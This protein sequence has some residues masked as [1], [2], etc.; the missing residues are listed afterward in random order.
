M[1]LWTE[2]VNRLRYLGRRG[3][4][5]RELDVEIRFHIE[6]RVAELVESGMTEAEAI[7]KARREFGSGAISQEDSRSAWQFGWLE[8][9]LAD[10]RYAAR[11]FLHSPTFAAAAI[12][13]LALGIG[14]NTL[15]F[16]LVDSVLLRKLPYS[17]PDRLVAV[18][19]T[20]PNQPDQKMGTNSGAYF[21][22][23]ENNT[24]FAEMGVGRLKEAFAIAREGEE[25]REWAHSQFFSQG[26]IRALGVDPIMGK[27]PE[28]QW[29]FVI[30]HRA[31]QRLLGG[32]PDVIGKSLQYDSGSRRIDAVLPPG[33]ELFDPE[34]DAWIV[35]PDEDLRRAFHSPNRIFTI[36][37]RMKPGVTVAQAQAEMSKLAVRVGE[38]LPESHKGWGVKVESLHDVYVARVRQPLLIL[39]GAVFLLLLI[40]CANV[41]GLLLAQASARSQELAM[42]TALGS[43]RGR[44][45]RQLLTE[46]VLLSV[47][48]GVLGVGLAW[49][50]LRSFLSLTPEN[51]PRLAE[52][53]L[54]REALWFAVLLSLCTGILFG[55]IPAIQATRTALMETLRD[56]TRSA[57]A[58]GLRQRLRASF[59]VVQIALALV[60]LVSSGLTIRSLVQLNA[61]QTGFD[62]THLLTVQ[63]PFMRSFYGSGGNTPRG[64]L[65]IE[66]KPGLTVLSEQIRQKIATV[67][68]VVS[69]TAGVTPPLGGAP[70]I[71]RFARPEQPLASNL[72]EAWAAEW[73][74]V[75]NDY[76]KTLK[77][78]VLQ[79]REIGPQDTDRGK[80]VAVINAA[81]ARR[82]WPNETPI[83]KLVQTD[84]LYDPP[85]EI[86]GVAGDIIQNRFQLEA[87]AQIY[88]PRGQLPLKMD[89]VVALEVLPT[90]YIVRTHGEPGSMVASIRSA[91]REVDR[92]QPI[93]KI[94]SVDEFSSG[95]LA[96]LRQFVALLALFG[97]IS[98]TL[99]V[100][101]LFGIMAHTVARRTNEIGI[102]VALGASAPA[103]LGLLARQ[104]LAMIGI[105]FAFGIVAS[106]ALTRLLQS[107]LWGVSATDPTTFGAVALLLAAVALLACYLPALRALKVDPMI[108]LR[109]Q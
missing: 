50:G 81:M 20:P 38:V 31:W 22:L 23:R 52:I 73:Y 80:P 47:I 86:V 45:V 16:T 28:D 39:Q 29:G 1:G 27:W 2:V 19:F 103:V 79:G 78:P 63:V 71:T 108:A 99:A 51:F 26:I 70:R 55:A 53:T 33:F 87:Q 58:S 18:W 36:I 37:A 105:G 77:L 40:A 61:T 84:I 98:V 32:A 96:N 97:G 91:I 88:V 56:A 54:N 13:C 89:M 92:V 101:G 12:G 102:R 44:I 75:H 43:S 60:L 100:V 66:F 64:G 93:N 69:A 7:T 11:S 8:D 59:V 109:H 24:V 25:G 34:T 85:R 57:T 67:P 83:G 42:R 30:S 17:D 35:Q 46:S 15:I 21:T 6:S 107:L 5:D 4:F 76:F 104:G 90:T 9:L 106:L 74:P 62:Q 82:F 94:R 10:L 48:G 65:A 41:A 95:Q 68:G 14:A 3:K 72:Q 49:A